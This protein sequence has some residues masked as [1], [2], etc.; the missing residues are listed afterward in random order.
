MHLA[1]HLAVQ[2]ARISGTWSTA[3]SIV[4]W[5]CLQVFDML[6]F[7]NDIGFWKEKKTMEGLSVKVRIYLTCCLVCRDAW[8]YPVLGLT[9]ECSSAAL[10]HAPFVRSPATIA[11][12]TSC[13]ASGCRPSSSTA[14]AR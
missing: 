14:C 4:I 5:H 7:K 12:L 3:F 13:C 10:C 8:S 9:T 11:K 2:R 1:V 6:A